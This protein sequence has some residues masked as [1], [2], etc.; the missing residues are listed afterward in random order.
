M[1]VIKKTYILHQQYVAKSPR[2]LEISQFEELD[3]Q[4]P[5]QH[6]TIAEVSLLSAA[7]A[8]Y[9]PVKRSAV[10]RCDGALQ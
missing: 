10:V 3:P 1:C 5:N 4:R 6:G 9:V 2:G 8:P 7:A